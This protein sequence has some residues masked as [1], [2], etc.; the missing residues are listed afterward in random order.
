MFLEKGRYNLDLL[1]TILRE[2]RPAQK[3]K[4]RIYKEIGSVAR[5][6]LGS[7]TKVHHS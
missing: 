6:I 3:P 2:N 1:K 4:Q 5:I 7:N